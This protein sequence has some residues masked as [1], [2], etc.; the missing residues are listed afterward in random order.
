MSNF[1]IIVPQIPTGNVDFP[2]SIVGADSQIITIEV[3]PGQKVECE[4]GSL[5]VM[6]SDMKTNVACGSCSRIFA[7]EGICKVTYTNGGSTNGFVGLTPNFPAKVVPV[8]L[9][10][11]GGKLIAKGGAYMGSWGEMEL[12]A[13]CDCNCCTCCCGGMGFIRQQAVGSGT[14]LLAASGTVVQ[15]TLA[16]G[17]KIIV[18]TDSI[19]GFQESVKMSVVA[20]G[21]CCTMCCGGEGMFNTQLEGPGLVI[22][23]SMSFEKYRRAIA[24]RPRPANNANAMK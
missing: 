13:N 2:Y 21:G 18:D 20:A 15:K 16:P 7:G 14:I 8:Q 6:S 24:P 10:S 23:Q 12:T 19:V 9:G 11:V 22:V 3:K 5:M 17:E 1:E 4:P